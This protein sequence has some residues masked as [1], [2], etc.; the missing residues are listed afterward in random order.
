M[1]ECLTLGRGEQAG[2][3]PLPGGRVYWFLITNADRPNHAYPDERAEVLRRV[4]GWHDPIPAVVRATEQVLH[5]D[6]IDIEPLP[7]FVKGRVALLGDAAHAMSPDLGQGACQAI[8]DAVVLADALDRTPD[9]GTGLTS[10]DEQRRARVQPM[11]A[12]A[13]K[14]VVRN[15]NPSPVAHLAM[16]LAARLIPPGAWRKATGQW[17]EWTPPSPLSV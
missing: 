17:S 2:L 16:T 12:A 11:A 13:R 8:E 1:Q 14:A 4:G 15:S 5:H 6:V 3:L 10:Y 7:T 9:L